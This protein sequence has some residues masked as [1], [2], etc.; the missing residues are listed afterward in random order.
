MH[1]P[2]GGREE[3]RENFPPPSSRLKR[4]H[5]SVFTAVGISRPQESKRG[6]G[7]SQILL[8]FPPPPSSPR[9]KR[10]VSTHAGRKE[11][12][13]FSRP[14]PPVVAVMEG[15]E[16][17]GGHLCALCCR[18]VGRVL[19]AIDSRKALPLPPWR[20]GRLIGAP[21]PTPPC[22]GRSVSFKSHSSS[23]TKRKGGGNRRIH[24]FL[25][26]PLI[27]TP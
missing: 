10:P 5:F 4:L 23:Q 13:N 19:M 11:G 18:S 7:C 8:V 25:S 6:G 9:G 17:G 12:W 1:L 21:S 2:K 22:T 14:P 24:I 16:G 27:W 15:E 26:H 20:E 3:G